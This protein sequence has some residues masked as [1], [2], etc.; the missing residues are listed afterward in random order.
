MTNYI[1]SL[2][3]SVSRACKKIHD[4]LS[5]DSC[6]IGI[7][8]GYVSFLKEAYSNLD[9]RTLSFLNDLLESKDDSVDSEFVKVDEYKEKY[10]IALSCANEMIDSLM[11][12]R[13]DNESVRSSRSS[14]GGSKRAS[15]LPKLN[16]P[17]FDGNVL[18]FKSFMER[19]DSAIHNDEYLSDIDKFNYCSWMKLPVASVEL[20]LP[21]KT[22]KRLVIS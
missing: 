11:R 3:A 10:F 17:K 12:V 18:H 1:P 21:Q 6:E 16:L 20:I 19:F 5:S 2:R 13:D 14:H 9:E 7:L 15:R 22:M 8:K 4:Y